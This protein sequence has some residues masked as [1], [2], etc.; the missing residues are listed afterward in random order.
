M[1]K[2]PYSHQLINKADISAVARVLNSDWLTQGP[3]IKAFEEKLARYTG[4][5]YA[6][7]VS[8]GTAALHIACLA[9]GFQNGQEVVV[10]ANT[11]AATA[12]AVVYTG[13]KPVFTDI[14]PTTGNMD[15][16]ALERSL[17]VKARGIIAVDFSGIPCEWGRLATLA[18]KKK[19]MLI[20]D[21]SHALGAAYKLGGLW[22]KIGCCKHA[23]MTT[24]SFHPLKSITTG[25]G[26]AV[27][28]NRRDLFEKLMILRN[29][30]INP[31][32][33][34]V[35]LGFNYRITD[36]QCA[37]GTSQIKKVDA[38][39][40]KRASIEKYY[41][42]VFEQNPYFDLL[43]HPQ[44]VKSSHHLFPILLKDPQWKQALFEAF[45]L[46]GLGVQTHYVPVYWHPFYQHLGYKLH[47]APR[48]ENFY[49]REI[50][51]PIYP[52][53]SVKE[54]RWVVKTVLDT[55]AAVIGKSL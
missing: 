46:K 17:G 8:S 38:F 3:G 21:A 45:S 26:G 9:A 42:K 44:G 51:L 16:S 34:M 13:A 47:L 30:G 36:I 2:I 22:H 52:G 20:D 7:A 1:K 33:K 5:K 35:T 50:S 48:A 54:Q 41:R 43:T 25:E 29:H 32:K 6:V 19:L 28:T 55:C 18:S 49:S 11:F 37:L 15:I 40:V 27:L 39:I 31:E 10:P 14:D 53:L 4:A 24:L 12:N 23:E